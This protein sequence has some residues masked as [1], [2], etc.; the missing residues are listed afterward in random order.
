MGLGSRPVSVRPSG[1]RPPGLFFEA[2]LPNRLKIAS[3]HPCGKFPQFVFPV[4]RPGACSNGAYIRG[5]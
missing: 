3:R 2:K 5:N 1:V 4:R